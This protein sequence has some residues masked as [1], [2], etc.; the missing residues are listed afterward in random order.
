MAAAV[1][2]RPSVAV[3]GLGKMGLPIAERILEGGFPL[4]VWNRTAEK[5]EALADRGATVLASSADALAAADVCVTMLAD[6]GALEEV[7]AGVLGGARPGTTLVDMSTVSVA[8]SERVA[9]RAAATGVEFLRAP[10]SGNP[11][12]VRAGNL[13]VIV[14]GPEDAARRLE[15]LLRSIGPKMLYVGEGERARVAKLVLQILIAGTAELLGEALVL[16]EAAGVDR[17]TLLEVIGKSAV[18]SPFVGYKT[19]PLLRDDYSATFT[20]AMMLKDI[21]LVLD[22]A[23]GADLTL[24]VTRELRNLLEKLAGNG[25]ADKDFM[26]LYVQ[27]RETLDRQARPANH[28]NE[29]RVTT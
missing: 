20:T 8:A 9:G 24:P 26:A 6:D 19:E 22:L 1:E 14:S 11:S 28:G 12:V 23:R 10:V 7:A 29:E 17:S 16:G 15:P 3:V 5:A 27:L 21:D 2:N 13:T 18:A 4:S 25:Y